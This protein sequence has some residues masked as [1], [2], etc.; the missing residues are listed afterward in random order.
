MLKDNF[1][2]KVKNS[3]GEPEELQE[4]KNG[5][6]EELFDKF[7]DLKAVSSINHATNMGKSLKEIIKLFSNNAKKLFTS[8]G[9]TVY[10]LS[11]DNKSLKMQN[12]TTPLNMLR[13]MESL[14]GMK[15]KE[16]EFPIVKGGFYNKVLERKRPLILSKPE[17]IKKMILEFVESVKPKSEVLYKSIKKLVPG[18]YKIIGCNSVMIVPLVADDRSVGI[19]DICSKKIYKN[20]DL[21]RMRIISEEVTAVINR[22]LLEDK[23]NFINKELNVIL[24]INLEGVRFIDTDFNVLKVNKKFCKISGVDEKKNLIKK[25]Y[26]VFHNSNCHKPTCILKQILGGA[27]KV[28]KEIDAIRADKKI[29]PCILTALPLKDAGGNIIGVAENFYDISEVR[30]AEESILEGKKKYR[31]FAETLDEII[32]DIDLKGKVTYANKKAFD[33]TG[34]T[35]EDVDRGFNIMQ[36]VGPMERKRLVFDF[37]NF[38]KGKIAGRTFIYKIRRKNGTTFRTVAHPNY[39]LDSRGK[40]T[41]IRV[42]LVDLTDIEVAEKKVKESEEKYRLLFENSLDGIYRTTL[43]GKYI[44]VNTSM[45]KMLGYGSKEELIA[46]DIP[47]QLYAR[48]EDRPGKDERNK[49][50]E[51]K[52]KKKDG[53]IIVVEIN[54]SVVYKYGKPVCY[55]GI[56]RDVTERKEAEEKVKESY[57]KLKKILDNV[58]DALASIVEIKDPYTSGHQKRVALLSVLIS[59]ELGLDKATIEA[60]NTAALIHDIGKINLPA[61]VLNRP[62]RLLK[63]EYDMVKTHSKLGYDMISQIDFPGPVA[64][65]VLQHHERLDGS[66][67]PQGLK[68]DEIIPEAKIIAVAD[69]VEA[70]SSHRPYRPALDVGE[71]VKEIKKGKG[72]LYDPRVVNACVKLIKDKKIDL[73]P[74]FIEI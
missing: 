50:F 67:Y 11:S 55:E 51:T 49:I 60:I 3:P 63:I 35:Q 19:I 42:V 21:E 74:T 1:K 52:L 59:R 64:D 18:I 33:E 69:V 24:D 14:I 54:S 71:A 45:V 4:D 62:G 13:K 66:G 57:E 38:L 15:I 12:Y 22:K 61:S 43:G 73:K 65:I 5:D 6:I 30:K 29:I 70:M 31:E 9:A 36:A 32:I 34:Y 48:K 10:L 46:I 28:K 26:K 41:G 17:D 37:I 8:L 20:S 25:C 58:I 56:V 27:K 72:K 44:D 16:V 39:L 7:E 2:D 68:G 53:S 47:T 40:M 23:L